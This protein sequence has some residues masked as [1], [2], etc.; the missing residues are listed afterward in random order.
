MEEVMERYV[1]DAYNLHKS[2]LVNEA[3]QSG[4][5]E[6]YYSK[7]SLDTGILDFNIEGNSEHCLVLNK[8]F[9]KVSFEISGNATRAGQ[10]GSA[11]TSADIS[12]ADTTAKVYAINNI[13]HSAFE[14]VE[15]YV[16]NEATTKVDKHYPYIAYL[17]TLKSYGAHAHQIYFT[18]SGFYKDDSSSMD[19]ADKANSTQLNHRDALWTV[20]D[21]KKKGEFI[22]RICSP[23]FQQEKVLP[24][25][26]S[27]RVVMKKSNDNFALMHETGQFQLKITEAVLM[28]Q[29]V[30]LIPEIHENILKITEEGNSIPY[31]LSTPTVNYYTIEASSSQFMR[32]DLF[33]GKTPKHVIIGMV[34]T[35]AYHGNSAKNPF[36]FKHFDVSEIGLYKDGMPY[37]CPVMKPDFG[38]SRFGETFL[39]FLK[40]LGAVNSNI[41]P[42]IKK[43]EYS[44]GYT[45]FSFDMSPDQSQSVVPASMLKMSSNIRLEMKF[46][47]ALPKNVTLIVYAVFENLMEISK[48]RRVK[49]TF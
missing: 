37:P 24:P 21:K 25:Q 22:G 48:D 26:V 40:S 2:Q 20:E 39:C 47:N 49:V 4:F 27:I 35:D 44:S 19:A 36:N 18:L 41:V 43:D 17:D 30:S 34:E 33:M 38:K 15:V 28:V 42:A 7:N 32:D 45:L 14:S 8:T 23:L 6:Y 11:A 5:V 29:K 16:G 9:L 10:S 3:C 12:T 31:V 13:L 1:P 46:K